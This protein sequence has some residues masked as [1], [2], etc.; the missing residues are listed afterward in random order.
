MMRQKRFFT[1]VSALLCIV[2]LTGCSTPITA[3]TESPYPLIGKSSVSALLTESTPEPEPD[4]IANKNT[5]KFHE[6]YCSSV[7]RMKESRKLYFIGSR[8]ELIERGYIP[9][10]RCK[11]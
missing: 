9:C 7:D 8:D 6:P 5:G 1:L 3:E 11:P 10:K 2:L 4:Y